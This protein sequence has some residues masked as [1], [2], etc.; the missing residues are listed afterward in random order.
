MA[1][2]E[3]IITDIVN[4][5]ADEASFLW[6]QHASAVHSP[7]YSLQQLFDLNER[8][9]AHIDGLRVAGEHGWKIAEALLGNE[10]P[11][12]FFPAAVLALESD[13]TRFEELILRASQAPEA[14]PGLISAVGW[15]SAQFLTRRVKALLED[16]APLKQKLGIAAC[17]MH[18]RDP[19]QALNSLL[20]TAVDSV[21][22]RAYRA[23]GE[24]GRKDT[25]PQLLSAL[26]EGKPE[27]QFWSAWSSVLL[28]DRNRAL[29]A[30]C[31]IVLIGGPRQLDALQLAL[32]TMDMKA[33]HAL[34]RKL[35]KLPNAGRLCIIGSGLIGSIE[36][37]PWLI[38]QME[39]P[40]LARIAAE[41]FVNITGADF[42]LD[43]LEA[44]PPENFEEGPTEDPDDEVVEIPEDI[45]LAWPDVTKIHQWWNKHRTRFQTDTRYFLG[46]PI[47]G[48]HCTNVLKEGY[49]RQRI[50]AAQRLC[51]LNPGSVLFPTSAPAWR[52]K[53]WLEKIA[54]AE[55]RSGDNVK[56]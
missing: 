10:N 43:Q 25:L 46:Q 44:E 9:E 4:E 42:N 49:Q 55:A 29:K 33:G 53:R 30:L 45:A 24:L 41:A 6:L 1:A 15:V 18:R 21:R 23:A 19:G 36:Y 50:M 37:V 3:K 40:Q 16:K 52:Q 7:N 56:D 22:I 11:E 39:D 17:A 51:L 38:E 14:I 32:L 31:N 34:L 2:D 54:A 8:L 27:A 28:G 13:D 26:D 5:H 47:T 48:G 35:K 12:D 20:E